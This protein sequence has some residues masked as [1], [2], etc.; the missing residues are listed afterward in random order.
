MLLRAAGRDLGDVVSAGKK[1]RPALRNAGLFAPQ[2]AEPFKKEREARRW[3][4]K[5]THPTVSNENSSYRLLI[6]KR[7]LRQ[8]LVPIFLR[9]AKKIFAAGSAQADKGQIGQAD[10]EAQQGSEQVDI[11][12][13]FFHDRQQQPFQAEEVQ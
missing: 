12:E 6:R 3:R 4:R 11:L 5:Q 10:D 2:G 8:G 13:L 1:K 7:Q 9:M